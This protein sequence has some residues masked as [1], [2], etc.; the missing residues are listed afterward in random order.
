MQD[1]ETF[2][3]QAEINQ[4]LRPVINTFDS[5]KEIFLREFISNVSDALDKIPAS[6]ILSR[7]SSFGLS[8]TRPTGPSPSSTRVLA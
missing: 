1:T 5:N 2:A 7:S 4:L 8:L 3:F 6:S